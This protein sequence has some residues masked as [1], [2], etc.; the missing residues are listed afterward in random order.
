MGKKYLKGFANLGIIPVAT[1][2]A[3]A[4]SATGEKKSLVGARTCAP[5]DNRTEFSIPGDDGVYDSGAEWTDT[6]LVVTV[7][8]MELSLLAA[9]GGVDM[10]E[11]TDELE[12]STFDV[13]PEFALT[14][15]ALR[16]DG[17]YRLYRYYVSK[18]SGYKI[19]H[20]TR[21][22]NNEAQTYELTF[23]CSPRACDGK[24]RGTKDVDKGTAS[25]WLDTIPAFPEVGD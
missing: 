4:Y 6:T 23:K 21:G 14:F 13:P 10:E 12:E 16:A 8:E 17:G 5:T 19:T 24:I 22:E 20:S 11:L 15:S 3:T 18:C 2:T 9:L 25:T 1:N 7:N